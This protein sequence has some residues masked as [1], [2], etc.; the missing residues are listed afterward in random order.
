M[1]KVTTEQV[2]YWLGSDCKRSEMLELLAELANGEYD[3]QLFRE[4]IA[5]MW[6]DMGAEQDE[7]ENKKETT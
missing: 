5:D 1:N 7:T 6:E 4:D 3:P 2:E